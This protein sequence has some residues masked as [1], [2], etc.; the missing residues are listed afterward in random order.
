[1]REEIAHFFSI[2][3]EL[4]PDRMTAIEGWADRAEAEREI[5]EAR[6]ALRRPER[7]AGGVFTWR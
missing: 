7:V 5:E 4:E 6:A 1:M 2:Y 3:K